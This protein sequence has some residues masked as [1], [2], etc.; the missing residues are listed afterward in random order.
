M[1]LFLIKAHRSYVISCVTS[2][3]ACVTRVANEFM[4][5]YD[6]VSQYIFNNRYL[7]PDKNIRFGPKPAILV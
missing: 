1:H 7:L 2:L 6:A 3:C 5:Q 4:M